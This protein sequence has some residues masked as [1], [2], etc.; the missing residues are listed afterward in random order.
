MSGKRAETEQFILKYLHE[1][2]PGSDTW[3]FYKD[4]FATMDD[5]AF[6]SFIDRLADETEFLVLIAPNFSS[7]GLSIKRN[8][9][10]AK[11]LGHEFF[12]GF[13]LVLKVIAGHISLQ[14]NIW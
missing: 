14:L 7:S 1:L 10:V 12:K 9:D 13:G 11:K 6:E 8:F 5:K 2:A 4:R 3:K